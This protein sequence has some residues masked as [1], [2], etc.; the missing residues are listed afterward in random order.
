MYNSNST[1]RCLREAAVVDMTLY[2]T[3]QKLLYNL[4][5]IA[6]PELITDKTTSNCGDHSILVANEGMFMNRPKAPDIS[7][8]SD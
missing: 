6:H 3:I 8:E 1:T 5:H 2:C 4:Q 7:A